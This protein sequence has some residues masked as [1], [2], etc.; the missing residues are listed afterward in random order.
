MISECPSTLL[1]LFNLEIDSKLLHD[2]L[3]TKSPVQARAAVENPNDYQNKEWDCDKGN[4]AIS[5]P[6]GGLLQPL[7]TIVVGSL[8][9]RVASANM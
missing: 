3:I 5:T 7:Q 6:S 1:D 2:E 4:A 8:V 9:R